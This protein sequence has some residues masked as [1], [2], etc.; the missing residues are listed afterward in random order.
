[1]RGDEGCSCIILAAP[2]RWDANVSLQRWMVTMLVTTP[3]VQHRADVGK[4][5]EER[6]EVWLG[7]DAAPSCLAEVVALGDAH[8]LSVVSMR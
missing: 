4:G 1:M 8:L 7:D 6:D 2:G 3:T 5:F